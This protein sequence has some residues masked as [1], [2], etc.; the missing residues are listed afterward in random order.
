ISYSCSV[1]G[2]VLAW[3]INTLKIQHK[4]LL[5]CANINSMELHKDLLLCCTKDCI[6]VTKKSG[7]LFK[8]VEILENIRKMGSS[9]YGIQLF[10]EKEQLWVFCTAGNEISI[11]EMNDLSKAPSKVV[12]QD[13]TQITCMLRVKQQIWVGSKGISQG[14]QKGKIYVINAE[15][16][17]VEKELVAHMDIVNSLCSAEDRYVLSG[18]GKEDGK[19]AIWKVE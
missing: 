2:N 19:V 15:K 5:P 10:A 7:L 4:F 16:K 13:C 3:D 8:R 14:K 17:T 9:F 18:S 6:L 12:L 11:F 1:D